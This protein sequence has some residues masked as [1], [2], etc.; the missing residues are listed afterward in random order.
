MEVANAWTL[1][2]DCGS[3]DRMMDQGADLVG[4]SGGRSCGNSL[5]WGFTSSNQNT[6]ASSHACPPRP[7]VS[8]CLL[9]KQQ[10]TAK[11]K[12]F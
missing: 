11:Y 2:R 3:E 12:S 7:K 10:R 5:W 1:G 6:A 4:R 9:T 8:V